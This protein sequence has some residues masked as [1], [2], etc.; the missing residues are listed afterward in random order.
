[1]LRVYFLAI[2]VVLTETTGI[3]LN[4]R[5]NTL[6]TEQETEFQNNQFKDSD[7]ESEIQREI[8]K[9][10]GADFTVRASKQ[11]LT[12]DLLCTNN[13]NTIPE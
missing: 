8:L 11:Y 9:T 1:M 2:V 6:S 5:G 10:R 7:L 13:H 4:R 3:R 12:V